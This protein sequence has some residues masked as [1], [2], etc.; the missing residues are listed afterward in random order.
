MTRI[1]RH[2]PWRYICAK[3]GS[4]AL[5]WK[6]STK[7]PRGKKYGQGGLEEKRAD[8]RA[9]ITCRICGIHTNE[10]HDKKRGRDVTAAT[11]RSDA[12]ASV[13]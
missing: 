10:V 7:R 8:K 11:V 2:Y 6:T 4:V 1:D 12:K 3:C 13:P 5:H 9:R